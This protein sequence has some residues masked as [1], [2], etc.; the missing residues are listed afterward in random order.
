[1]PKP[2]HICGRAVRRRR[3]R[4]FAWQDEITNRIAVAL[5]IGWST[6]QPPGRASARTRAI[7]FARAPY[8]WAAV[9]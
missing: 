8:G 9:A 6:P 2:T 5:D 1:M 7:T 3:R 4:L